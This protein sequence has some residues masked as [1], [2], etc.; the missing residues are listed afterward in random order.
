[1]TCSGRWQPLAKAVT[2]KDEVLVAS[3]VSLPTMCSRRWNRSVLMLKSSTM[4][5]ITSSAE[6]KASKDVVLD[7]CGL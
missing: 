3:T 4:A 2:D 6:A 7:E 1:M 5:S